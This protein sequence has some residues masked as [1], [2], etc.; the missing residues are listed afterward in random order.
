MQ[1]SSA[2]GI[3]ILRVAGLALLLSATLGWASTT[4]GPDGGG[5]A[6]T[7][8]VVYSFIVGFI[9]YFALA[10]AGLQPKAVSMPKAA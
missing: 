6:A 8:S 10:K 1:R 9:V 5:Y 3:V 4:R 7:D 2:V